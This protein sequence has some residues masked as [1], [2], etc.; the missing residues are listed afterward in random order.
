MAAAFAEHERKRQ[1]QQKRAM[2]RN[3]GA[4]S[5]AIASTPPAGIC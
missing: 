4:K 3:D 2:R 1:A 5:L